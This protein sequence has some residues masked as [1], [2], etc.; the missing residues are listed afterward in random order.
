MYTEKILDSIQQFHDGAIDEQEMIRY[1]FQRIMD[2]L[3]EFSLI[4]ETEFDYV[5]SFVNELNQ[6]MI[7]TVRYEDYVWKVTER[8]EKYETYWKYEIK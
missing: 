6:Y 8:I 7:I 3:N 2:R 4:A 5:I 1:I